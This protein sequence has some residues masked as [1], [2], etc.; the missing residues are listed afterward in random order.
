ML[1][2]IGTNWGTGYCQNAFASFSKW[3]ELL[4][5]L[6]CFAACVVEFQV[7]F[8]FNSL[9]LTEVMA[10]EVFTKLRGTR[11]IYLRYIENSSKEVNDILETFLSDFNTIVR[12]N[13]LK[14]SI[15]NKIDKKTWW[16]II[17][18]AKWKGLGKEAG[19]I[20][21]SWRSILG[22]YNYNRFTFI[23][24]DEK[25]RAKKVSSRLVFSNFW[26]S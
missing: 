4:T 24:A 21:Y 12:L 16:T 18:A 6:G 25:C 20:S 1:G 9:C 26:N 2:S 22:N 23:E 11:K 19:S 5:F 15:L 3:F 10:E 7:L 17:I 8:Y 13:T 14:T